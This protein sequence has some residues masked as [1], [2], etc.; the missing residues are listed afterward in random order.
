MLFFLK[1]LLQLWMLTI[2]ITWP[3]YLTRWLCA[4]Y[5]PP[6]VP[7]NSWTLTP[8]C[9]QSINNNN[10]NKKRTSSEFYLNKAKHKRSFSKTIISSSKIIPSHVRFPLYCTHSCQYLTI[11]SSTVWEPTA[12]RVEWYIDIDVTL[13]HTEWRTPAHRGYC[14][15]AHL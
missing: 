8:Q 10:N 11:R 2:D 6:T 13:V 3:H 5:V 14:S 15:K 7:T 1:I 12:K 9:F 4:G